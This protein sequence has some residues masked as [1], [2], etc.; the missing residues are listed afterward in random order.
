ME[1]SMENKE[2]FRWPVTVSRKIEASPQNIW[3]VISSPGNVESCHPFCEKNPVHKWP[4]V[5]SI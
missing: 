5:G 2:Q 1:L 4:G 3:S